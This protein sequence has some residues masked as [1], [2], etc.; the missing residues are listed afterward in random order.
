MKFSCPLQRNAQNNPQTKSKPKTK[1]TV[2]VGFYFVFFGFIKFFSNFNIPLTLPSYHMVVNKPLI[3]VS[4]SFN[5]VLS[6]PLSLF[7]VEKSTTFVVLSF[8]QFFLQSLDLFDECKCTLQS[9]FAVDLELE[10]H[11][12]IDFL[13]SHIDVRCLAIVVFCC[14]RVKGKI[15]AE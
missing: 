11:F 14:V 13:V 5:R 8:C 10:R 4:S 15:D 12:F 6:P 3:V 7:A 1:P 2:F 9:K